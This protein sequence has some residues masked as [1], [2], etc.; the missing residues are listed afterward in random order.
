MDANTQRKVALLDELMEL[1]DRSSTEEGE[2]MGT[3]PETPGAV[4]VG[5]TKAAPGGMEPPEEPYAGKCPHCG[6]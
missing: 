1:V 6:K 5:V 3:S 2:G 4:S